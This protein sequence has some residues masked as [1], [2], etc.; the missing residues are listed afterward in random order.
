MTSPADCRWGE[1]VVARLVE[2]DYFAS[3]CFSGDGKRARVATA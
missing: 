1:P 2:I 3:K